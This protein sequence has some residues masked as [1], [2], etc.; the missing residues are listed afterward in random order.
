MPFVLPEGGCSW[1]PTAAQAALVTVI[2]SVGRSQYWYVWKE[3]SR[4]CFVGLI[5][6]ATTLE[7]HIFTLTICR[8]AV[9]LFV[10]SSDDE[11][12]RTCADACP[13]SRGAATFGR[14]NG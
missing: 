2:M 5:K 10:F 11:I 14:G 8:A 9:L 1:I 12:S 6:A 4:R 7:Y 13:I 3:D